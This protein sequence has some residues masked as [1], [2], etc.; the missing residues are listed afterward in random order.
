MAYLRFLVRRINKHIQS[1]QNE[2]YNSAW[3][4]KVQ[5]F[6]DRVANLIHKPR[7]TPKTQSSIQELYYNYWIDV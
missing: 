7:L 1:E 2:E 5:Y 3:G 4:D 6:R